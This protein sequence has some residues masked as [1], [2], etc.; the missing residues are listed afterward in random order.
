MIRVNSRIQLISAAIFLFSIFVLQWV[1]FSGYV[2]RELA[3]SPFLIGDANWYLGHSYIVFDSILKKGEIPSAFFNDPAGI[4]VL[5]FSS[6]LYLA[7]GASRLMALATNFIPYLLL[8]GF[9]FYMGRRLTKSWIFA[10][11]L[12]GLFLTAAVPFQL[13]KN[14]V[15]AL[16]EYQRDF[17]VFC[18]FGVFIIAVFFS[19]TFL[20]RK[21]AIGIGVIA[22]FIVGFRYNALFHLLGIYLLFFASIICM[23]LINN[24]DVEILVIYKKRLVNGIFSCFSMGAV[25]FYPIWRARYALYN[26]Y[27]A[28]K[29]IG[30]KNESFIDIYQQ[31]VKNLWQQIVY[32]PKFILNSGLGGLFFKAAAAFVLILVIIIIASSLLKRLRRH[33]EN[34]FV[35]NGGNFEA[36]IFYWF[37]GIS[38]FAP[39]LLLT[40]YP[41]RSANVGILVAAPFIIFVC[42]SLAHLYNKSSIL[43]SRKVMMMLGLCVASASLILG[44]YF[45]KSCYSVRSFSSLNKKDFLEVGRMYD[46]IVLA[47]KKNGIK[48]P[49][50]SVNFSENY[51]L[52]CGEALTAYQYE[53]AG[54]LFRVKAK[55]GGDIGRGYE[56]DEAV[57]LI[58]ESEFMLL[59]TSDPPKG[60]H[61]TGKYGMMAHVLAVYPFAKSMY[62]LRPEI[63]EHVEKN[64]R[65]ISRYSIFDRKVE[66]YENKRMAFTPVIKSSSQMNDHHSADTILTSS[67]TIWHSKP[68]PVYPQWLEFK[69]KSPVVINNISM[70]CQIG[71][72]D[73]GP[74]EFYLQGLDEDGTWRTLLEVP[75]TGFKNGGEMKSWPVEN[76]IPFNKYRVYITKNNGA[77]N[78]L[79]IQQVIFSYKENTET[80]KK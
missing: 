77:H 53:H 69:Y 13:V 61:A 49:G 1:L 21:W 36:R 29:L 76:I 11:A 56:L 27:F 12:L 34:D 55:L 40:V 48:K 44:A 65:L 63:R 16:M 57:K 74:G 7:F 51:V 24:K 58:L 62:K 60:T 2:E 41:V 22:G 46:D 67:S 4:M 79:T 59:D 3:W 6:A 45:Q 20:K 33:D 78:L 35:E 66:L 54:E 68:G 64:F 42:I 30:P 38:S 5:L 70:I 26:H 31:G 73:R 39:L 52:G 47:S 23:L 75:D 71:A 15:L 17:G 32:Y 18:L 50:I 14:N 80:I 10:F 25:S 37:I 28:G 8:Q 72:P 9:L 19:D 43:C